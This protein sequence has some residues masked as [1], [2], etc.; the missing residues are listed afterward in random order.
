MVMND[1]RESKIIVRWRGCRRPFQR[2]STPG[3]SSDIAQFVALAIAHHQLDEKGCDTQRDQT[4]AESR[5]NEPY[6]QG[7]ILKLADAAG[8]PLQSKHIKRHEGKEEAD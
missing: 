6:L 8:H 4:G 5:H 2:A 1:R 7:G 3:V